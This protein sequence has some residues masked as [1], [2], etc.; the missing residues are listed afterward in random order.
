MTTTVRFEGTA[1]ENTHVPYM[2]EADLASQT[3]EWS[4]IPH[5]EAICKEDFAD[6]MWDLYSR[7]N[8]YTWLSS[9]M[10]PRFYNIQNAYNHGAKIYFSGDLADEIVTDMAITKVI[11]S[12]QIVVAYNDMEWTDRRCERSFCLTLR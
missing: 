9:R 8:Q 11:S 6:G 2:G 4:G 5:S 1:D 3:A 7:M 12:S 10:M